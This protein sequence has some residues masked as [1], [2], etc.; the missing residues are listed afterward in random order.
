MRSNNQ[1]SFDE[2]EKSNTSSAL[3][4]P[5][6]HEY[7]MVRK[8]YMCHMC[9]REFK[10]MAPVNELVDVHCP[11]CHECFVEEISSSASVS[12]SGS[13]AANNASN[14]S[15]SQVA[16]P[17]NVASENP[18]RQEQ[19]IREGTENEDLLAS[20]LGL[21]RLFS[22]RSDSG[23]STTSSATESQ[24]RH[25]SQSNGESLQGH[26]VRRRRIINDPNGDQTIIEEITS[27]GVIFQRMTTHII[28]QQP[29]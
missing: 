27:N 15:Q 22:E 25:R 5:R 11:R 26:P 19:E 28:Q 7:R 17:A 4:S 9:E 18:S 16:E 1:S 20:L 8:A 12:L 14:G 21:G 29:S 23:P 13:Q 24:T 3:S 10:Q 6:D 2:E